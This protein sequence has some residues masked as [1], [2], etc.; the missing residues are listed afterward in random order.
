VRNVVLVGFQGAQLL[1]MAGPAD[2]FSM[3]SQMGAQPAF[4]VQIVS[5]AGGLLET[6]SGVA[7]NTLAVSEVDSQKIDTLIVAGGARD[8]LVAA[9]EDEVLAG[10]VRSAAPKARRFGSVCSGAFALAQWGLLD[11]CRATTHWSAT[12]TLRRYYVNTQVEPEA[13]FV[14]DGRVWTS[15]GVT[16]GIDMCLAMVEEDQGRELTARVARQLLLS[17]RR[18]G[19]QSQYSRTLQLQA[20]RYAELIDWIRTHLT[21]TLSIERLAEHAGQ[22]NRSF[23]RHFEAQTG[24]TP[25]AF[26]ESQRLNAAREQLEAGA[27]LKAAA[28]TAGLTS[29]EQLARVFKRRLGMS[30]LQYQMV[31]CG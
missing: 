9:I 22:S 10:W 5:S 2:V 28:R 14:R 7:I 4:K 17:V 3:A 19:N 8:G 6:S 11:G 25:A 20:G 27:S 1:D 24:E 26:V 13:L 29:D 15:G 30:P 16:A 18:L 31:H 21:E 23:Q 12:S